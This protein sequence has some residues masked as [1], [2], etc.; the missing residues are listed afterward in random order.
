MYDIGL[1]THG[2]STLFNRKVIDRYACRVSAGTDRYNLF[3]SQQRLPG[4]RSI[5]YILGGNLEDYTLRLSER[6]VNEYI[7]G[8]GLFSRIMLS[9][10]SPNAQL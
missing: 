5:L 7:G 3:S 4:A 8:K 10:L 1:M 6:K 9:M 2:L